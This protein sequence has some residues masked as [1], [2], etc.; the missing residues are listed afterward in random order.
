MLRTKFAMPLN[1]FNNIMPGL[2]LKPL[3][4]MEVILKKLFFLLYYC[5]INVILT[6][7]VSNNYYLYYYNNKV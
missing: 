1:K 3:K 6:E 4:Y 5:H 7:I 2:M